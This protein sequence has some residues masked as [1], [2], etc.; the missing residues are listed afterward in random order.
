[1]KI[2]LEALAQIIGAAL[3]VEANMDKRGRYFTCEL[4]DSEICLGSS[5]HIY[6]PAASNYGRH[7]RT[8]ETA[9]RSC[10]R[11]LRGQK[12]RVKRVILGQ[13]EYVRFRIP[14]TLTA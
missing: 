10:A 3:I 11:H 5:G 4:A 14:E 7:W 6:T 9:R 13:T 1:M 12:I 8:P 2:D